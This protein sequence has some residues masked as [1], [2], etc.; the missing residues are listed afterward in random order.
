M[1]RMHIAEYLDGDPLEYFNAYS[2]SHDDHFVLDDFLEELKTHFP[3]DVRNG[4]ALA[5][6][7]EFNTLCQE[8]GETVADYAVRARRLFVKLTAVY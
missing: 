4:K 1:R 3:V 5:I 7:R 2:L 6:T 8:S